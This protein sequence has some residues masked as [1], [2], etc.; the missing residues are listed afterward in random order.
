[1]S[2]FIT[3]CVVG[4]ALSLDAFSLSLGI[5]T[6]NSKKNSYLSIAILVGVFHFVMPLIG[7]LIGIQLQK[8]FHT[9]GNFL[10]GVVFVYISFEMIR[11]LINKVDS[12]WDS[13]ILGTTLFAFSVSIDSFSV[14]LGLMA[15]TKNLILAVFIFSL[16]S[17]TCTYLGLI[18]GKYT[19]KRFGMVATVIGAIILFLLGMFHLIHSN[20]P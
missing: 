3:I 15:I 2:E 10:I 11:G 20:L 5:G 8:V 6:I 1:M 4:L 18:I 19:K 9:S 17:S 13:T 12:S 16:L 14:G 7:T